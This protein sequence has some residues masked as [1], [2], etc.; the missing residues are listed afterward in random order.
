[1]AN[2]SSSDRA[3]YERPELSA[4]DRT[5]RVT[6]RKPVIAFTAVGLVILAALVYVAAWGINGWAQALVLGVIVLTAI[7]LIIAVSPTRRA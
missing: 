6:N 3:Q 7:G 1:M 4:P 2:M 5:M